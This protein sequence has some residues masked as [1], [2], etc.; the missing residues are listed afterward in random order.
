[1]KYFL[2]SAPERI[3]VEVAEKTQEEFALLDTTTNTSLE[4]L[5]GD[6]PKQTL[7]IF[8]IYLSKKLK[9][10]YL[11]L[12]RHSPQP[13]PYIQLLEKDAVSDSKTMDPRKAFEVRISRINTEFRKSEIPIKILIIQEF[14]Y[15]LEYPGI[16]KIWWG[17]LTARERKILQILLLAR[18]P[19]EVVNLY[20][21]IEPLSVDNIFLEKN[22]VELI[23]SRLNKKLSVLQPH[24]KISRKNHRYFCTDVP[25]EVLDKIQQDLQIALS[26]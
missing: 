8:A 15:Y 2:E 7:E 6:F 25:K 4:K 17:L 13:T 24:L 14:G 1:M 3:P 20:R 21:L 22:A 26:F 23:V 12:V 10:T 11:T 19:I 9:E 18:Q 5:F 16:E